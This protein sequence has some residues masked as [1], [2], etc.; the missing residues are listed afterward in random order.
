MNNTTPG[1]KLKR[2]FSTGN[3]KEESEDDMIEEEEGKITEKLGKYITIKY[4]G[5]LGWFQ[6]NEDLYWRLVSDAALWDKAVYQSHENAI[7][8]DDI[9]CRCNK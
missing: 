1:R 2:S 3:L 7:K 5:H 9:F 4:P 8:C 6:M